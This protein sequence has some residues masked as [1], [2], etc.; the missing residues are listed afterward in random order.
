M[1]RSFQ[2]KL[3]QLSAGCD[4][5]NSIFDV[6]IDSQRGA[7]LT[8]SGRVLEASQVEALR[9]SFSGLDLNTD[10]I[11]ILNRPQLPRR[12]VAT[13][14]TGVYG[15]PTFGMPLSSELT[16]GTQLEVLEAQGPWSLTR[17]T[18]GYLGWV[19]NAYLSETTGDQSHLVLAPSVEVRREPALTA[20]VI[21]RL[22]SGTA[23]GVGEARG[24][25]VCVSANVSGW[26]PKSALRAIKD[27]PISVDEKRKLVMEDAHRMIGT[28]YLWGGVSGNGIDC[29]GFARLL[30]RWVGV[31]IPRDADMQS[32]AARAVEEPF[33]IGDLL[34]FGEGDSDREVSHVGVSLG[35]WRMIHSSRSHNGVYIDDVRERRSL[36]DIYLGAGSFLR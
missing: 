30:H 32:G 31:E 27:I 4:K 34:F 7:T 25:W 3:D 21:T 13:N 33:Q 6:K 5:R 29:S 8:L 2:T 35:G 19:Y 10:S 9:R 15:Q 23:V 20:D 16:F 17:Q 36:M 24:E 22:V 12:F 14:L 1:D 11:K 18:D 26:V 28:P